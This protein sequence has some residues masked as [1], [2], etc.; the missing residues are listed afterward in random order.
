MKR[1]LLFFTLLIVASITLLPAQN[2]SI[3]KKWGAYRNAVDY[4]NNKPMIEGRFSLKKYKSPKAFD[5]YYITDIKTARKDQIITEYDV[6]YGIWAVFDSTDIYVNVFRF[7][8]GK[9]LAEVQ[10]KGRYSYF[11]AHPLTSAGQEQTVDQSALLGGLVGGTIAAVAVNQKNADKVHYVLDMST[12]NLHTLDE[13]YIS[14]ILKPEPDLYDRY[15]T[16]PDY[17]SSEVRIKY[18]KLLNERMGSR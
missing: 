6:K 13:T 4:A 8:I 10:E 17:G 15:I 1:F 2:D 11:K 3:P 5:F 7:G 16:E 9:G 12:G 18:I 14:F